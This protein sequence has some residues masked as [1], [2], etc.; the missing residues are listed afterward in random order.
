[1]NPMIR[2]LHSSRTFRALLAGIF[3]ALALA[4]GVF[5]G[6]PSPTLEPEEFGYCGARLTKLCVVSFGRDH[7]GGTVVN[8]FVP[9]MRYPAFY[10]NI[11]RRTGA[12]IYECSWSKIDETGVFC[13][14]AALNLGEGIEIQILAALDDRLLARGAFTVNAFLVT[15]PQMGEAPDTEKSGLESGT[16]VDE[17]KTPE[18]SRTADPS[19]PGET[20]TAYPNYP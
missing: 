4:C 20:S 7:L 18:P 9:R 5:D 8:L 6:A 1:M 10:L 13:S 14:G 3:L 15:T 2:L 11:V 16:N 19:S 17:T 12:D